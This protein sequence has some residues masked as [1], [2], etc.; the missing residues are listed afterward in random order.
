MVNSRLIKII[1]LGSFLFII[2]GE[3]STSGNFY[4]S[5]GVKTGLT[6]ASEAENTIGESFFTCNREDKCA[7]VADDATQQKSS[8]WKKIKALRSE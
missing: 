4:L 2:N 1:L 6:D 7:K 5:E 8:R 3:K